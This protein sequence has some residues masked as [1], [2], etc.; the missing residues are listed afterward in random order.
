[1]F[2][3]NESIHRPAD[4][5]SAGALENLG[6]AD[7]TFL[8]GLRLDLADFATR[9]ANNAIPERRLSTPSVAGAMRMTPAQKGGRISIPQIAACLSIGRMAVYKLLEL[10]I[11][12]A[13]HLGRQWIVTRAAFDEWQRTCGVAPPLPGGITH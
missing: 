7:E 8:G 9:V 6:A 10:G 3:T 11:I 2:A 12:P 13:I 4:A 1:M 5:I